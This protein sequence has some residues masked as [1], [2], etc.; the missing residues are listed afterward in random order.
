M[1]II[2]L[3]CR[4]TSEPWMKSMFVRLP[5][6]SNWVRTALTVFAAL[7]SAC[8]PQATPGPGAP[9][10]TRA[11]LA[12][13]TQ[14]APTAPLTVASETSAATATQVPT[15]SPPAATPRGDQLE[16]TDPNTVTLAS[17]GLQ[18]IEFFA[19]W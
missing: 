5:P 13:A 2:R 17:G 4:M 16:A 11:L 6:A 7:L 8:A 1:L 14:P 15:A 12:T 9:A 18:L 10:P 3:E 19:F